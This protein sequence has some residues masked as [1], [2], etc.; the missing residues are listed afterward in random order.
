[1]NK[2]LKYFHALV[3][4]PAAAHSYILRSN[5]FLLPIAAIIRGL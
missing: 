3:L 1:M 5:E 4:F 2:N